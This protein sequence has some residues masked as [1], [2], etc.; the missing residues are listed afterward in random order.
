MSADATY[1]RGLLAGLVRGSASRARVN[2]ADLDDPQLVERVAETGDGAAF[3]ELVRRHEGRVRGLLMRMTGGDRTLA[4]DLGQEVFLR[5]YK[6]LAKFEGRALFST[7]LYRITYNVFLNHRNR[8]KQLLA[9]PEEY[10]RVT[11]APE[12]EQSP[13]RLDMRRDLRT[14]IATLPERYRAVVVLYYL[15]DVSYPE[16]AQMLE[17][18]L[19]TVKTHLHRARKELRAALPSW[20]PDEVGA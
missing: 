3:A 19:G 18:P 4:D 15:E 9:L 16:I 6:G 11:A 14:A 10:E 13:G 7:W 17:M 5:A 12:G 1:A 2:L 20:D 8:S